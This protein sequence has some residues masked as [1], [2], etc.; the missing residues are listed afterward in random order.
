MGEPDKEIRDWRKRKEPVAFYVLS[1]L[2]TTQPRAL[3][4]SE[5]KGAR[6]AKSARNPV[7]KHHETS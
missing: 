5:M 3:A 2:L 1:G 6:G 4:K 7:C